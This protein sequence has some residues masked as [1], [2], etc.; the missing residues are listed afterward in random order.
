MDF[1][2]YDKNVSKVKRN[3]RIDDFLKIVNE[4][5]RFEYIYMYE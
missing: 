3:K 4:I 1:F 2:S 5:I